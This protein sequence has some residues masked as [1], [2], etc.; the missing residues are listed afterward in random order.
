MSNYGRRSGARIRRCYTRELLPTAMQGI[1]RDGRLGLD[2][3]TP[4]QLKLRVLLALHLF[5][6]GDVSALHTTSGTV[7]IL[8]NYTITVSPRYDDLVMI[9]DVPGNITNYLAPKESSAAIPG[10]RMLGIDSN[11]FRMV[12]LPTGARLRVTRDPGC[13]LGDPYEHR[14]AWWAPDKAMTPQE[15]DSIATMPVPTPDAAAMIAA[16][17]T[18]FNC[19]DPE[20]NWSGSWYSDP[21]ERSSPKSSHESDRRQLTGGGSQWL[22]RWN[23]YPLAYD[24]AQ[25]ICDPVF[26]LS[27]TVSH[28][29]AA[30]IDLR[31][32]GSTL[33]LRQL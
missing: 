6:M 29:G 32:G 13:H 26:G 16:L 30:G 15:I 9:T 5:N 23:G 19:V 12:H 8:S 21:L 27:D 11:E 14:R 24:L 22:L 25:M 17:V 31:R 10:V 4:E 18:R 3:C 1:S 28:E 33:R 7:G 2:E 20:K